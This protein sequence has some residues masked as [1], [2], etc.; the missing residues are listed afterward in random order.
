VSKPADA[1]VKGTIA[2][3]KKTAILIFDL[4]LEHQQS[5]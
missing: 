1:A 2:E 3:N 4:P 5:G